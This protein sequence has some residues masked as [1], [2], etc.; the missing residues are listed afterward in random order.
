MNPAN[1]SRDAGRLMKSIIGEPYSHHSLRQ[2]AAVTLYRR[3]L[4]VVTVQH[5]LGHASLENTTRYLNDA[6]IIQRDQL[7]FSLATING[8]NQP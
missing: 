5:F 8:D 2:T 1:I 6:S 7:P 3:T 4:D